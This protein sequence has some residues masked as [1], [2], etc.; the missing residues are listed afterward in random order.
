MEKLLWLQVSVV[1]AVLLVLFLRQAMRRMPKIYSYLLWMVVFARLICP[2]SF[3]SRVA[4]MPAPQVQTET[5]V[6]HFGEGSPYLMEAPDAEKE[7]DITEASSK[8]AVLSEIY[9]KETG[10]VLWFLGTM[11]ILSYNIAAYWQLKRR[12][13]GAHHLE[14][15]VYVSSRAA[16]P[17]TMGLIHPCIYLPEGIGEKEQEYILCHERI[18]IRRKDYLVK[19]IAFLLTALYWWNPFVWVAFYFMEQDM[20]MSCDEAVMRQLDGNFRRE[21]AQSLLNFATGEKRKMAVPLTFGGSS[22]KKR[23]KNI[24][25]GKNRKRWMEAIGVAAL[26]IVGL[27]IFTTQENTDSKNT[28]NEEDVVAAQTEKLEKTASGE[29]DTEEPA[30][31]DP[32]ITEAQNTQAD[33]DWIGI[34]DADTLFV[35]LMPEENAEVVSI[36]AKEQKIYILGEKDEFY[37]ISIVSED[38]ETLE[39]YVKKEYVKVKGYVKKEYLD[40]VK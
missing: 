21:Y 30:A 35:R 39:G 19:N 31:E 28:G 6:V 27:L 32:E 3:E 37:Q 24:L 1:I 2:V 18:H 22:V 11:S 38:G 12:M 16:T 23:V 33:E 14:G 26:L 15:N 34:V 13:R 20:E 36:L 40:A 7:T 10:W 25:S 5:A 8:T 4:V 29:T 17:F 9:W